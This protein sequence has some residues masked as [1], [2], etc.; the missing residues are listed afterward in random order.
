MQDILREFNQLSRT[1]RGERTLGQHID[2]LSKVIGNAEEVN[3]L[4]KCVPPL[5]AK[6]KNLDQL[7]KDFQKK[8]DGLDNKVGNL[9]KMVKKLADH[10]CT[11]LKIVADKF[12]TLLNKIKQ[13]KGQGSKDMKED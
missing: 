1:A 2:R 12:N 9:E 7:N 3:N 6:K 8:L 5:E 11:I 4:M 10:N 13:G